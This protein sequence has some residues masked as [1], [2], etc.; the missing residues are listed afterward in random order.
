MDGRRDKKKG[1]KGK[2]KRDRVIIQTIEDGQLLTTA[3]H[4]APVHSHFQK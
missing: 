2:G 3:Q 4:P 1:E